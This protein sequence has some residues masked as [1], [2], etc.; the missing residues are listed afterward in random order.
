MKDRHL[1]KVI[2]LLST[3]L[4]Y[5][6]SDFLADTNYREAAQNIL[7]TH[8]SLYI[9]KCTAKIIMLT[10]NNCHIIMCILTS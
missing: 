10:A 7:T 9:I 2:A 8:P 6:K 1:E 3:S 5:M 4:Y